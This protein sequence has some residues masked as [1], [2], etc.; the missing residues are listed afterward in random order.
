MLLE[1]KLAF[2]SKISERLVSS[3]RERVRVR[4]GERKRMVD[5]KWMHDDVYS[6]CYYFPI[7]CQNDKER[8]RERRAWLKR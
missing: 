4:E 6:G 1:Y 8:E 2:V 3:S 5:L 7:K